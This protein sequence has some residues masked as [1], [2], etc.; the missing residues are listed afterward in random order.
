MA[1]S[2]Y[3]GGVET[4]QSCKTFLASDLFP[5]F[6]EVSTERQCQQRCKLSEGSNITKLKVSSKSVHF[7][8]LSSLFRLALFFSCCHHWR[9][10]S[11][12]LTKM[13]VAASTTKIVTGSAKHHLPGLPYLEVLQR[14]LLRRVQVAWPRRLQRARRPR[15][16]RLQVD[17]RCP[18][19]ATSRTP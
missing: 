2:F 19:T 13:L 15:P 12:T 6:P 8:L 1:P 16:P 3:K 5:G 10:P 18:M 11:Q 7:A 4:K 9:M 17:H 14:R